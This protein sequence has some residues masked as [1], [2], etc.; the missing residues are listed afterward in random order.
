MAAT[1]DSTVDM[2]TVTNSTTTTN[3]T[4]PKSKSKPKLKVP[5]RNL[6]KP[7]CCKY[8]LEDFRIWSD[9]QDKIALYLNEQIEN[10]FHS[11]PPYSEQTKN[12]NMSIVSKFVFDVFGRTPSYKYVATNIIN[13][14][15]K[16]NDS[17]KGETVDER[18][19]CS[20]SNRSG[21]VFPTM[22]FR[23]LLRGGDPTE[24]RRMNDIVVIAITA[25]IEGWLGWF[26]KQIYLNTLYEK[27]KSGR[28]EDVQ[29]VIDGVYRTPYEVQER[30]A[31]K[32]TRRRRPASS[33]PPANNSKNKKTNKKSTKT[34]NTKSAK[35]TKSTRGKK[36][37]TKTNTTTR[38][39]KKTTSTADRDTKPNKQRKKDTKSATA[40]R[41][42][43]Q[44]IVDTMMEVF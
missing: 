11:F 18:K 9:A 17:N 23:R 8:G 36:T 13:C 4:K 43:N 25:S 10:F 31:S 22:F 6:I 30:L 7:V 35:N 28:V 1:H 42:S 12:L 16:W 40:S 32:G 15:A 2:N 21:L 44:E 3:T 5:F 20:K 41:P 29:S 37:T 34:K 26:V 19:Y 24:P 38:K 39:R 33:E 14:L 27:R